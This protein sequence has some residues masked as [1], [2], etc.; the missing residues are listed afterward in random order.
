VSPAGLASWLTDHAF[1]TSS[2]VAIQERIAELFAAG[3]VLFLREH[4]LSATDRVDFFVSMVGD[5]R[6]AIGVE[7][8]VAGSAP[9]LTRQLQRYA[10]YESVTGLVVVTNRARLTQLPPTLSGKPIAV[11]AILTGGL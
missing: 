7:V 8:K 10:Q 9:A 2:E 4:R 5:Y 1:P 11:A 3:G 6:R